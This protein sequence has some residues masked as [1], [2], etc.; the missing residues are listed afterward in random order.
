M[1]S[2]VL[3]GRVPTAAE[4]H[5]GAD[6]V[7][8]LTY[9]FWMRRFG[10]DSGAVGSTIELNG[11][12]FQVIGVAQKN[13]TW[14]AEAEL[15]RPLAV[16]QFGERDRLRRD[17]HIFR[18]AARLRTGVSVG[19]A[20]AKLTAMGARI[21]QEHVNRAGTNWKLHTLRDFIIGRSLRQTVIVLF[22]ASLLVLLI[23][24]VNVANLLLVRGAARSREVAIRNALGAGWKR[25]AAQFL[26]ESAALAAAGGLAGITLGY[27]GL[28]ALIRLAPPDVPRL[29]E[30]HIDLGV[31]CFAALLCLLTAVVAGVGPALHAARLSPAA[32]FHETSRG[33]SGG[34]RTARLRNL[35]VVSEL[36][37]A[38]V[39]LAGAGLLIRSFQAMQ[40]VDPGFPTGNLLT[41]RLSLPS[42]RY[43][44]SAN[45]GFRPARRVRPEDSRCCLNSRSRFATS[46][47]R[48]ILSRPRIPARRATGPT[49]CGRRGRI[50]ERGATRLV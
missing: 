44:G 25:V 12:R 10:G 1:G 38:L 50:V 33:S 4:N 28:K 24:C 8:A 20:Q 43:P 46:R 39:L 26:A 27:W 36:S 18:A 16:D 32:S 40:R 15:F 23:A 6:R 19:Q 31:L 29:D 30:A 49:C 41:L 17:N 5:L 14:P 21:A 47:R 34:V 45:R 35:L 22:G 48:R 13:S 7:A 37:L 11:V 2:P 42:S 3:L 9:N